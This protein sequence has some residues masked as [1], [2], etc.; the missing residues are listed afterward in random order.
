[1]AQVTVMA[2]LL[3]SIDVKKLFI[4]AIFSITLCDIDIKLLQSEVD[5]EE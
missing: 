3:Q 1:M 5:D 4:S 2:F